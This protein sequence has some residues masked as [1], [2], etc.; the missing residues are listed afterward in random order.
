MAQ[1]QHHMVVDPVYSMNLSMAIRRLEEDPDT[2][3]RMEHLRQAHSI[4]FGSWTKPS[5]NNMH[6][7]RVY[8]D[9]YRDILLHKDVWFNSI[10]ARDVPMSYVFCE[11]TVGILGTL[12]TIRRQRGEV[13]QCLEILQ[14]D[15]EVLRQYQ[16]L[17]T[18][19]EALNQNPSI[20]RCVEGLTYKYN[21]IACNAHRQTLNK[22]EALKAFRAAAK[23]EIEQQMSFD[24]Q[25]LAY[26]IETHALVLG[27]DYMSV[28]VLDET[29]DEHIWS[30]LMSLS[31]SSPD[32]PPKK[33]EPWICDGCGEVEEFCGDYQRCKACRRVHYC[34]RDCQVNHWK[35]HKKER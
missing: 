35:I 6:H 29:P 7:E 5:H 3:P 26:L 27:K 1:Q 18:T 9:F 30:M 4:L 16:M 15:E 21:L 14:L 34:S 10:Y 33:L 17:T 8:V 28:D 24:D 11:W 22:Q 19:N 2:E 23:Y 25:N 12:A 13:A 31:N 32:V 20:A